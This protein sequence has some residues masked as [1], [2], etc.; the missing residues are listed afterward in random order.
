[1]LHYHFAN[2]KFASA[3]NV[4]IALHCTAEIGSIIIIRS[5]SE[6]V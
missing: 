6:M 2:A 5:L 4:E 3:Q 1:M